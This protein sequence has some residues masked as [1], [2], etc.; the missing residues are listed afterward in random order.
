MSRSCMLLFATA[1]Q[2]DSLRPAI[3]QVDAVSGSIIDPQL[4]NTGPNGTHVTGI[5]QR[6]ATDP[7][8]DPSDGGPVPEAGKPFNERRCT[9]SRSLSAP[10]ARVSPGP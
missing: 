9:A 4:R 5:T 7:D 3:Y 10:P 2:H 8:V 6:E 1:E